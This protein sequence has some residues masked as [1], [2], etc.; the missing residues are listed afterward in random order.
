MTS[1][2]PRTKFKSNSIDPKRNGMRGT[3]TAQNRLS[4]AK[5]MTIRRLLSRSSIPSD[6][7]VNERIKQIRYRSEKLTAVVL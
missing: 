6:H 2:V 4:R 7:L 3:A 5:K 1:Q